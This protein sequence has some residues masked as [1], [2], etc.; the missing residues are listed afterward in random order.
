MSIDMSLQQSTSSLTSSRV[1][2]DSDSPSDEQKSEA[3]HHP[4]P[5]PAPPSLPKFPASAVNVPRP[6]T[7]KLRSAPD[8]SQTSKHKSKSSIRLAFEKAAQGGAR[9]LLA[10]MPH[11]VSP[12]ERRAQFLRAS[13]QV[14]HNLSVQ[15]EFD[16]KISKRNDQKRKDSQNERQQRHR[17]KVLAK[18]IAA[19]LR[20]SDGK[21]IKPQK[22]LAEQLRDTAS[23]SGVPPSK[24]QPSTFAEQ[25]RP[26][27]AIQEAL[28]Q[29]SR[30]AQG[31]K[32]KHEPELATYVNWHSELL[33]PPIA[34]AAQHPSVGPDMSATAIKKVLT[35]TNPTTY[36]RLSRSTI[37]GWIDRTGDR[38]RWSD[39]ALRMAEKGHL[40][41][42]QGGF[43]GYLA[44]YP[45]VVEVIIKRLEDLRAAHA[46]L[47]LVSIRGVVVAT[48]LRMAPE[49]FEHKAPDGSAFQCSDTFLRRFLHEQMH[50]SERRSTRDGRKIPAD[51]E[52]QCTKA[53]FRLAH[54]IKEYDIPSELIVNTDQ[55]NMV[56]AQGTKKTWAPTGSSQVSVSGADEKRAVTLCVSVSNN[57]TLLPFQAVYQGETM[58]STPKKTAPH[59]D[60]TIAAGF[61]Y[62]YGTKSSYWSNQRTMTRLVDDIIAPYFAEQKEELK[63]PQDHKSIWQIDVWSVHRSEQFRTWL[64]T[65]HPAI[66]LHF[67]PGGCTGLMQA[68][69]VGIQRPLKHSLRR[70]YHDDVVKDMLEQLDNG[71]ENPTT[72]TRVGYLRDLSVGWIWRAYTTLNKEEIVKKVSGKL[73]VT[74]SRNDSPDYDHTQAFEKCAVG[75]FNLS[76]ACLTSTHSRAKLRERKAADSEFRKELEEH[77][78]YH[79]SLPAEDAVCVE[80][81]VDPEEGKADD[82]NIST[83]VLIAHVMDN[84]VPAGVGVSSDGALETRTDAEQT[85]DVAGEQE[86]IEAELG[87]GK[88]KRRKR[89]LSDYNIEHFWKA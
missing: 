41:G 31:R 28:F 48:I 71:E 79:A 87:R 3:V 25:S 8:P 4:P 64:R 65:H 21:K 69:D 27:R 19:G 38:A 82:L 35:R 80:D 32:R 57:G 40:Q 9:G 81:V 55:T 86:A 17:K 30:A 70:S 75:D 61:R 37:R 60:E 20:S 66:L 36:D 18:E 58:L 51:W 59:Y 13:E 88:R 7:S 53:F 24:R 10:F 83:D 49:I 1:T 45:H 29:A 56:Y 11:R 15:A 6:S 22:S 62:E 44:G 43:R 77:D 12:E 67:V 72:S 34:E 47:D 63:L 23:T 89:D 16:A 54:D 14:A 46:P 33:W 76:Y 68:C 26:K 52:D 84:I 2:S 73:L 78:T 39:A 74:R 5:I 85:D 42:G 50:W